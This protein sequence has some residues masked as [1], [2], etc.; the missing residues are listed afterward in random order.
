MRHGRAKAARKTLQYFARTIGLKAP[1]HVLVDANF[2]VAMHQQNLFPVQERIEKVLQ[3]NN[4]HSMDTTTSQTHHPKH[5][6]IKYYMLQSTISEL[7]Q[8]VET[9]TRQQHPKVS[10]FEQ[11]LQWAREHCTIIQEEYQS[12]KAA[13]V[14]DKEA[15]T[16]AVA[17]ESSSSAAEFIWNYIT[18]S[19]KT[20]T[21]NTTTSIIIIPYI[22]AS[23]DEPLLDKLRYL[24]T[25]PLI[26]LTNNASVLILEQPSKSSR[27]QA[28]RQESHKWKH[29]LHDQEH[30]LVKVVRREA[31]TA[32]Q[33]HTN[34]TQQ[35]QQQEDKQLHGSHHP[36]NIYE[37]RKKKKAGGANPL[38]CKKKASS[39]GDGNSSHKK[40]SSE[41]PPSAGAGGGGGAESSAT[42]SRRK[43]RKKN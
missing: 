19:K 20:T 35:H 43:R 8:L 2:L 22:V 11:A 15:T 4:T 25:V 16:T 6:A 24:G 23:Q 37:Q 3:Q 14:K 31:K 17:E 28:T 30:E 41:T 1:Y 26:R 39:G 18:H 12:S 7:K 13:A 9:L 5:G 21:T 27:H 40:R 36:T 33:Q 42:A 34:K 29:S 38:S 32:V 10:S